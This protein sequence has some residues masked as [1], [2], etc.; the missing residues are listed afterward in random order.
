[1]GCAA[2]SVGPTWYHHQVGGIM[3][4]RT[5]G[6]VSI[7]YHPK[8]CA[9][10]DLTLSADCTSRCTANHSTHADACRVRFLAHEQDKA[11]FCFHEKVAQQE[12]EYQQKQQKKL[13]SAVLQDRLKAAHKFTDEGEPSWTVAVTCMGI[14]H[15]TST[16]YL[17]AITSV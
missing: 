8:Q 12:H 16:S 2:D 17:I 15:W 13:R 5:Q 9:Q 6:R 3:Q 1:M 11:W 10:V 4:Q 14:C 7:P